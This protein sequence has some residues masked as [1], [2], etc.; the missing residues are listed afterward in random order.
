MSTPKLR[1]R[2]L[3]STEQSFHPLWESGH[4]PSPVNFKATNYDALSKVQVCACHH[5][6]G[7][8]LPVRKSGST[9]TNLVRL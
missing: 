6:L 8:S 2:N 9:K 1:L 7:L 4:V 3:G 5:E